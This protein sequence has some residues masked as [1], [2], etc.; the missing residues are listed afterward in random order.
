MT[1]IAVMHPGASAPLDLVVWAS[2]FREGVI[3]WPAGPAGL[4]TAGGH[5]GVTGRR[6][7]VVTGV[8]RTVTADGLGP[9]CAGKCLARL[10]GV[11]E[12]CLLIPGPEQADVAGRQ[13]LNHRHPALLGG[14]RHRRGHHGLTGINGPAGPAA[15]NI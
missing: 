5:R 15:G 11:A 4:R 10:S 2:A 6:A 7:G 14:L 9:A 8:T 3:A 1:R 12:A 13:M